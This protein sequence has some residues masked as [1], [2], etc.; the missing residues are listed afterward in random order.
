M[1]GMRTFLTFGGIEGSTTFLVIPGDPMVICLGGR[2]GLLTPVAAATV[3]MTPGAEAMGLGAMTR[4]WIGGDAPAAADATG[5][6]CTMNCSCFLASSSLCLVSVNMTFP[7]VACCWS[8]LLSFAFPFLLLA[9]RLFPPLATADATSFLTA[10][11]RMA[12]AGGSSSALSVS[13]S[14]F[15]AVVF[16]FLLA[17]RLKKRKQTLH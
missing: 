17:G 1:G 10:G 2:T 16:L 13:E 4:C 7:F 14:D 15:L 3:R 5:L 9:E 8:F 12:F 6:K 11:G